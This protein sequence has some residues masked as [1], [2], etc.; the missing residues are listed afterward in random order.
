MDKKKDQNKRQERRLL[1]KPYQQDGYS[2]NKKDKTKRRKIRKT[3]TKN[4]KEKV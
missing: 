4:V 3:K 2:F 1:L